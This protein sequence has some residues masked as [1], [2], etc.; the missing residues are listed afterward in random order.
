MDCFLNQYTVSLTTTYVYKATP[1]FYGS[2]GVGD[3]ENRSSPTQIGTAT[4]WLFTLS[5]NS[6]SASAIRSE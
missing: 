2:L 1:K 6:A 5:N 4:D 3:N